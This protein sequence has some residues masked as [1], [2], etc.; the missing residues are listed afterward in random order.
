MTYV[1]IVRAIIFSKRCGA[2]PRLVW[3]ECVIIV[4]TRARV[5]I[6]EAGRACVYV[7]R[8]LTH[9]QWNGFY[10]KFIAKRASDSQ[11]ARAH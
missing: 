8:S 6:S 3:L 2:R 11:S 1:T 9:I 5:V 7:T 10:V 4:G